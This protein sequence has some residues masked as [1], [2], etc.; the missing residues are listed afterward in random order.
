MGG[1]G[2]PGVL[3]PSGDWEETPGSGKTQTQRQTAPNILHNEYVYFSP[4]DRQG[5][6]PPE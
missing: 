6:G 4:S 1:V 5:E 3:K 2:E